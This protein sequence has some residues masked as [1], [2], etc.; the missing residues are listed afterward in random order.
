MNLFE[1]AKEVLK[2]REQFYGQTSACH[3]KIAA[4]WSQWKGVNFTKADVAMM[5]V[6]FK[7]ARESLN[8]KPDNAIDC[9]SYLSFYDDFIK[10]FINKPEQIKQLPEGSYVGLKKGEIFWF[11][12]GSHCFCTRVPF[13]NLQESIV[14]TGLTLEAAWQDLIT[15]ERKNNDLRR[16]E[17][18]ES[19]QLP[20]SNT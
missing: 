11:R 16:S 9:A 18:V 13:I 6:L 2:D 4:L 1:K 7:I 5:M 10:D 14:G 8:H 17:I 12:E 19:T 3:E 20:Q 15:N